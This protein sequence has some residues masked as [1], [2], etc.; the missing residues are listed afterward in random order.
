M[1]DRD[2]SIFIWSFS[3]L[4]VDQ[5]SLCLGD[6]I[7]SLSEFSTAHA[8]LHP[9][10]LYLLTNRVLYSRINKRLVKLSGLFTGDSLPLLFTI[11][12]V[13]QN[14]SSPLHA[15]YLPI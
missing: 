10:L 7:N 12:P 1:V 11:P 14:V 3:L 15:V 5:N 9:L 4:E 13:F 6:V 2:C 8:D